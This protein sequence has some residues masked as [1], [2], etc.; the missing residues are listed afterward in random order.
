MVRFSFRLN[1]VYTPVSSVKRLFLPEKKGFLL[2]GMTF[3]YYKCMYI[4]YAYDINWC[5]CSNSALY[6]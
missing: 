6:A 3:V 2:S 4:F 1:A 5:I